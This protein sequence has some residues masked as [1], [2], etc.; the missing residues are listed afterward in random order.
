[1]VIGVSCNRTPDSG[2]R[3]QN[4]ALE[5]GN[6]A[7][8]FFSPWCPDCAAMKVEIIPLLEANGTRVEWIDVTTEAGMARFSEVTVERGVDPPTMAPVIVYKGHVLWTLE[9][10]RSVIVE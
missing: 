1:M 6:T 9:A 10:M 8:A 3:R 7:M 4:T 5:M 2:Y